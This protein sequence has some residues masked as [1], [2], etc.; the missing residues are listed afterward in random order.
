MVS[1]CENSL[2]CGLL[3]VH[4]RY[5]CSGGVVVCAVERNRVAVEFKKFLAQSG[6]EELSRK[7]RRLA[8]S[9]YRSSLFLPP[10]PNAI[11]LDTFTC[12]YAFK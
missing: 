4:L 10:Q 5:C 11:L 12:C 8:T 1:I 3:Y 7:T 9:G 6:K 2:L